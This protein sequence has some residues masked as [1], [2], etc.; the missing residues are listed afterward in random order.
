MTVSHKTNRC[1]DMKYVLQLSLCSFKKNFFLE[2]S[3][4]CSFF[5]KYM[6]QKFRTKMFR[7]VQFG[8]VQKS[9]GFLKFRDTV[10]Y[11][12]LLGMQWYRNFILDRFGSGQKFSARFLVRFGTDK[13]K[14][15]DPVHN[16]YEHLIFIYTTVSFSHKQSVFSHKRHSA[17]EFVKFAEFLK[18]FLCKKIPK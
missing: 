2:N 14:V 7:P 8:S 3:K 10:R 4:I 11:A 1:S 13:S 18:K 6:H 12:F 17:A 5:W 9:S 15:S 16:M